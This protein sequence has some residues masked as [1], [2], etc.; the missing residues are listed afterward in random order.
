[1]SNHTQGNWNGI[2]GRL[3]LKATDPVFLADVQEI[4]RDVLE[5]NGMLDKAD[6]FVRASGKLQALLYKE[7]IESALRTPGM[8][9][10]QLLQ[11]HD[12]PGQ[13]TALGYRYR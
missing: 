5:A 1:M 12:F 4:F 7:E 9:G 6:D 11:L 13:G 3:E 10:I 2:V 8:G